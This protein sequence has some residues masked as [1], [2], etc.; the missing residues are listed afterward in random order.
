[1]RTGAGWRGA[2]AGAGGGKRVMGSGPEGSRE[3]EGLKGE[4]R[5]AVAA[6]D[7]AGAGEAYTRA[8]ELLGAGP[9]GGDPGARA[10]AYSNRAHCWLAR[11]NFE[12]AAV[13]ASSAAELQPEW[14]KPLYRLAQARLGLGEYP[15]AVAA[16]RRGEALLAAAGDCSREF[17]PLLDKIA[18][19]AALNGSLAGFDGRLLEVRSAGEEAWLG[20]PAPENP[21]YDEPQGRLAA[22]VED[23]AAASAGHQASAAAALVAERGRRERLSFRSVAEALEAAR[24]GDR[25][26]LLR[27]THNT[28]GRSA[29]VD[30]RVL[31]CGEG[32][33]EETKVDARSNA[34]VLRITRSAV[35]Q[36]VHIDMVGFRESVLIEGGPAVTPVLD[37]CVVAC[38][39]DDAVNV[40]GQAA[41][42][43]RRCELEARKRGLKFMDSARGE[44]FDCCVRKAGGPGVQ[45]FDG[46]SPTL[47]RCRI[48]EG[49]AEGVVVMDGGRAA[50]IGCTVEGN[51][52]PGVDVSGGGAVSLEGCRVRGNV[53]GVFLW[54]QGCGE[55]VDCHLAG[56]PS[57]PVLADEEA[58]VAAGGCEIEGNVHVAESAWEGLAG[59]GAAA[60]NAFVDAPGACELPRETGPFKFEA[61]QFLRKQ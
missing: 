53:G 39:G 11:G 29:R 60:P 40:A 52:G 51:K 48:A 34:P 26:L 1:M 22:T 10:V 47:R 19:V 54:D 57:F 4:G 45:V 20:R 38:S 23:W 44:V 55:L 31:I 32:T 5:A 16:A 50:L 6:G 30:K 17:A 15:A 2:A 28:G 35:V 36:N 9:G 12:L 3:L 21:L 18:V 59:A 24:D 27:G 61:D 7:F 58:R 33:L 37:G 13:D 49:A 25:V 41:P 43:L 8:L 42:F 46:A 56:G 14:P